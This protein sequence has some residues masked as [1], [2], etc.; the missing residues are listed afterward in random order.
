MKHSLREV[1]APGGLA[2]MGRRAPYASVGEHLGAKQAL[3]DPEEHGKRQ[4]V[5]SA[6]GAYV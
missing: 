6:S 1:R 2:H 4:Q 3:D 5:C